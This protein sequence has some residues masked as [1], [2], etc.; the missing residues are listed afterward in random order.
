ML[1]IKFPSGVSDEFQLMKKDICKGSF[2][3][4]KYGFFFPF[5]IS[6]MCQN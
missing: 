4:Q 5:L 2:L 1:K 3:S 6:E